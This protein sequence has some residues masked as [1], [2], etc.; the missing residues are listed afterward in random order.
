MQ[1]SPIFATFGNKLNSDI[2][3]CIQFLSIVINFFIY[4]TSLAGKKTYA[5]GVKWQEFLSLI[6]VHNIYI[7]SF[8]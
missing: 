5:L 3:R 4:N 1:H 6:N 7:S 2:R 8:P